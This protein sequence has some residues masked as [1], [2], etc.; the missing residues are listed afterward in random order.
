[1]LICQKRHTYP[2]SKVHK[3]LVEIKNTNDKNSK[4]RLEKKNFPNQKY[5]KH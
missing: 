2:S 5:H 4:I 3:N 1:M